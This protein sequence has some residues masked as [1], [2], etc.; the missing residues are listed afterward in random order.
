M[1]SL[2]LT[3][4]PGTAIAAPSYPTPDPDPFYAQT[5]ATTGPV[6]TPVIVRRTPDLPAF[7]GTSVWQIS[8]RS[9][10]SQ[11]DP[12]V[13]VTTVLV[14][15]NQIPNGPLLSFQHIVNALGME[16][17]PSRTLY[18]NAPNRVVR[19]AGALNVAL[20]RGWVI[21]IPDHLVRCS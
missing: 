13:A 19:E 5:E 20:Q 3:A 21:A 1:I 9:T 18:S 15:A 17:A 6:G 14:P 4:L 2:A 11:S 8:F 12:I 7:P 16:C 10:N